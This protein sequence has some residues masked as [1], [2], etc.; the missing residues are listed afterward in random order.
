[1]SDSDPS[2]LHS[3]VTFELKL[4]KVVGDFGST[5]SRE[6][7]HLVPAHSYREVT[8]GRGNLSALLDLH[9]SCSIIFLLLQFRS[10]S[11]T[12][13]LKTRTH[14]LPAGLLSILKTDSPHV[15]QPEGGKT[16]DSY[17]KQICSVTC[18][19]IKENPLM[20][21]INLPCISVIAGK[22]PQLVVI[23]RGP[24]GGACH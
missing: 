21:F 8:A 15:I 6:D 13:S 1:M 2:I 7:E 19:D 20:F 17:G 5:L 11:K 18:R 23:H 9:R 12:H 14:L 24:V 16:S 4:E 10:K 22:D 3:H